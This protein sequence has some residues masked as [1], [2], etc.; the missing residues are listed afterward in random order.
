MEAYKIAA[1]I[2]VNWNSL[3]RTNKVYEVIQTTLVQH[4]VRHIIQLENEASSTS[5]TEKCDRISV[6]NREIGR[7]QIAHD[8]CVLVEDPL[9]GRFEKWNSN[10]G[11]FNQSKSSV[12]SLC[13]WS[14]HFSKGEVLLCDVQGT[15]ISSLF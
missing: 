6:N 3:K 13:H 12:Q 10:S 11:F 7:N 9:A 1:Q 5:E 15:Y 4:K 2:V 8:E 14:Y